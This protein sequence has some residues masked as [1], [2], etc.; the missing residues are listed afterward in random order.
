M[1]AAVVRDTHWDAVVVGAGLGGL[2]AAAAL[3]RRGQRVLVA[4][5]HDVPG[6]YAHCFVRRPRGSPVRYRFDV[7]LH[8]IGG[9]DPDRRLA[10]A[11]AGLGV[12]ERLRLRR[13]DVVYRTRGPAHDLRVAADVASYEQQLAQLFPDHQR[14]IHDLL[15]HL[16]A[17]DLGVVGYDDPPTAALALLGRS[18]EQLV[19]S[20]VTDQRFLSLFTPLWAYLGLPPAQLDAF[21]FAQV[22]SSYHLGGCFYIEGGGQALSD[23][24]VAVIA[25][26]GGQVLLRA[27]VARIVTSHGRVAGVEL[28]RQGPVHAPTVISNASAPDTFNRLLDDPRLAAADRR[29]TERMPISVSIVEAYLGI[30]GRAEQLGLPDR[31]LFDTPD[32]DIDAQWAA[33]QRGDLERAPCVLANHNLSDPASVP[34]GRS[35]LNA[36]VLTEGASWMDLP[37]PAYRERKQE[38]QRRL[39]D[40]LAADLPDVRDR[41]ELCE[42]GTPATMRRYSWNPQGAIY[43]IPASPRS[44]PLRRPPSRTSVPGLYLAGAWTFPGGGFHGAITSGLHAAAVIAGVGVSPA[45]EGPAHVIDPL[46]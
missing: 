42:L 3:T 34:A 27:P 22:W 45:L 31:L 13:F 41:L 16:Q 37:E 23:A 9:L 4:E 2:A 26:G 18:V 29:T 11:L 25:A 1:T 17:V 19:G 15:Q 43:G 14:G 7:A 40:R 33:L 46:A 30:R 28:E 8:Q 20:Y 44:H 21:M 10:R 36:A 12:L 35:I 32:Y 38:V 5:Q 6:G 39:L 24:F